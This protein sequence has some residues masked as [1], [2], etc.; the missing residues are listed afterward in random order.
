M[1]P[2]TQK[3]ITLPEIIETLGNYNLAEAR[4]RLSQ[5]TGASLSI[6]GKV[7]KVS[8]R[9]DAVKL[10][11]SPNRES[12]PERRMMIFAEF[13]REAQQVKVV[14]AKIRKGSPVS[15]SGRFQTVGDS[16]VTMY[17]CLLSLKKEILKHD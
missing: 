9:S 5:L 15:I 13:T 12:E 16:A 7:E 2:E 6:E 17:D 10:F 1:K 8:K 11:V 4:A 14:E 3:T